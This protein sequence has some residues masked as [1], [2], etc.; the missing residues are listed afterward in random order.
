MNQKKKYIF[1][2]IRKPKSKIVWISIL[3]IF[4]ISIILSY[5]YINYIRKF[6]YKSVDNNIAELSKQTASQLELTITSQK[7]FLE[8]IVDSINAGFFQTEKEILRQFDKELDNYHFTRFVILDESGSGITSDGHT[9]N[10][11][12]NIKDFFEQEEVYLSDN[13]PSTVSNNQVNIYSK[14]FWFKGQKKVLFATINMENYKQILLRRLFNGKGRTY[15]INKEGSIL[16]DSF[17]TVNEH[18]TILYDHLNQE[19]QL[20]NTKALRNIDQMKKNI[21]NNKVGT[22]DIHFNK[23]I[24]FIHYEKVNINDWYVVTIAPDNIIAKELPLFLRISLGLCFFM[25]IAVIFIFLYIYALNEKQNRKLYSIAY[26]DPITGLGNE[27]YFKEK[28]KDY[29]KVNAKNKYVVTI[30]INK[31]KA[32][33]NIYGY[34]F[35]NQI[36]KQI[37]KNVS[38]ILPENSL[39]CRISNDIF[40]IICY[41]NKNIE[42]LLEAIFNVSSKLVIEDQVIH[43]NISIGVYKISFDEQDIV[44]CLDKSD[45]ARS[46]IKGL[47]DNYYYIFD[48]ELEELLVEEQRIESSM[49]EALKRQEFKVFYQPKIYTKDESLAGA[50]ALVRWHRNDSIIQPNKFIPLFEKNKFILKLDLYIFEQVCKDISK[51][52][53]LYNKAPII[54]INVS[55]VHFQDEHFIDEYVKIADKYHIEKNRIDLEITESATMDSNID[56]VKILNTIKEKGFMISIDDFGTGYSSLSLLQN[57]PIDILKIDKTFIDKSDLSSNNNIIDYI[58]LISKHI[59][60]KTIVEGIETREQVEFIKKI[61]CD[62]IQGYY[63]SKPL[64][65]DKFEEYLRNHKYI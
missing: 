25:I 41:Y 40:A 46:K 12:P 22:F 16:I 64:K 34:D 5:F 56:I 59:G 20:K 44:R 33:N 55:K 24:Y 8:L 48:E 47:Y 30:D 10:N 62:M 45:I 3:F 63:Y 54:S 23:S 7:Q 13:R 15:L 32:L 11:Y 60:V 29:L 28:G 57:M 50:E 37:S 38:K 31:F 53:L 65:K 4:V 9:V 52:N 49:N 27:T 2:I 58:V 35:C 61:E 1:S 26:V 21:M 36:L 51:W 39:M 17:G 42:K 6:T 43:M 18:S 19:Y 14:T